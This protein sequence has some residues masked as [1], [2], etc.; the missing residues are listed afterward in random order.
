M[1]PKID[2]ADFLYSLIKMVV[3]LLGGYFAISKVFD[4]FKSSIATLKQAILENTFEQRRMND[5]LDDLAKTVER[6]DN[7]NVASHQKIMDC[8][9]D[10]EDILNDHDKRILILEH[11][12]DK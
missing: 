11:K 8:I 7:N 10:V 6:N 5:H 3:F 9:D 4:P 12:E 1:V 2:E